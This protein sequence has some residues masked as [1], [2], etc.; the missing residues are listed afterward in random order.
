MDSYQAF[1]NLLRLLKDSDVMAPF[2]HEKL[3]DVLT[4]FLLNPE[5]HREHMAIVLEAA[6]NNRAL[7]VIGPFLHILEKLDRWVHRWPFTW[8]LGIPQGEGPQLR[9]LFVQAR[10]EFLARV[11]RLSESLR[12]SL[13]AG[14]LRIDVLPVR[15][16]DTDPSWEA[17][18]KQLVAIEVRSSIRPKEG[19]HV[20]RAAV[21]IELQATPKVQIV[22][23]RPETEFEILAD[24]EVTSSLGGKVAQSEQLTGEA[25]LGTKVLGYEAKVKFVDGRTHSAEYAQ[26]VSATLKD[27]PTIPRVVCDSVGSTAHWNLYTTPSYE[28]SGGLAFEA[29]VLVDRA[30]KTIDVKSFVTAHFA[31]WGPVEVRTST[32][33]DL[34]FRE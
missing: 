14:D 17:L 13:Q 4:P 29:R 20:K 18:G 25:A 7:E 6:A 27:R 22:S 33:L 26:S 28:P 1:D 9:K 31:S 10:E 19:F 12:E 5:R 24:R 34:V 8:I 23:A 30:V 16:L 21:G 32:V 3:C 11:E 15:A 2:D